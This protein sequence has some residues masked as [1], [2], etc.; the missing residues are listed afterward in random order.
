MRQSSSH[1]PVSDQGYAVGA[2]A[3]WARRVLVVQLP[4]LLAA[5]A[6]AVSRASV[7]MSADS[8]APTFQHSNSWEAFEYRAQGLNSRHTCASGAGML[9]RLPGVSSIMKTSMW[10]AGYLANKLA[11]GLVAM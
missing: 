10:T 7:L 8:V 11:H 3:V 9:M 2:W 1:C 6:E 4:H 5:V